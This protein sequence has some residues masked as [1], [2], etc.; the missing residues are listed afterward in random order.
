[1]P[2]NQSELFVQCALA[3]WDQTVKR[4]A[5]IFDRL[6]DEQL[7]EEIAPGKNRPVYLLG[8]LAAVH[9][10]MLPLLGLGERQYPFLDAAFITNADK[11]VGEL[12]KMEELRGYWKNI[13]EVL[14]Q[15]FRAL[16]P[17]EWL[18]RHT[19]VSEEDFVKEPHR[20]RFNVLLSRTNHL[21]SHLGQLALL[22][23]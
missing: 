1:M 5:A 20:N 2:A 11:T 6:S 22:K 14:S 19:A 13:N 9:D 8:H 4:V 18:Q 7:L 12:P 23:K 15:R 3:T 16:K 17:E 10:M 21:S